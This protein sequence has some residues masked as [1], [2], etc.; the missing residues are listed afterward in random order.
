[1]G[2]RSRRFTMDSAE[3]LIT[4]AAACLAGARFG[5][6]A[7]VTAIEYARIADRTQAS[8]AAAGSGWAGI[9]GLGGAPATRASRRAAWSRRTHKELA[10][11][12]D[13]LKAR[14]APAT[15]CLN[16]LRSW[17]PEAEACPPCPEHV[18]T[19]TGAHAQVRNGSKRWRL[20]QLPSNWLEQLW[21]AAVSRACKHTDA[22]AV[23]ICTGCRPC[24]VCN[25]VEVLSPEPGWLHIAIAGSK[26]DEAHGQP[27]RRLQVQASGGP[28][29]HLV[30]LAQAGQ[31]R[32]RVRADCSPAALSMAIA[33]LGEACGF[34]QRVSAYDIRHA[35]ADDA[36]AAFVGD[37]TRLA[38]WLGHSVSS[39]ARHYGSR[40]HDGAGHHGPAPLDAVGCRKVRRRVRAARALQVQP[41]P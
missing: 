17:L 16:R 27:W 14:R 25:G 31:G 7:R 37:I 22:L 15:A 12:L 34:P 18:P 3:D 8:R 38:A 21:D 26:V 19:P 28:A 9:G 11:A 10:A 13:D 23:L 24:E 2:F 40:R 36:R 4:R 39:T 33:D 41:A 35:R 30:E 1:M 32:A 20:G 6:L 29:N 5:A